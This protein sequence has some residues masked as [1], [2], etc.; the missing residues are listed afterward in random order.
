MCSPIFNF[1]HFPL[2]FVIFT[3]EIKLTDSS[4]KTVN[5]VYHYS[6]DGN[7][8]TVAMMETLLKKQFTM[9]YIHLFICVSL[10]VLRA[11]Q[12]FSIE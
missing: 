2:G 10:T 11:V 12:N 4:I 7:I 1:S 8:N 6:L 9:I 3:E 5:K